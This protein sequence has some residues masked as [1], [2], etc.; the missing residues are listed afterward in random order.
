MRRLVTV[1]ALLAAA[2]AIAP[3]VGA[4]TY[5]T[6]DGNG[7]P[8]VG[9]LVS[10]TQYSDGTW[11]YCSGT[12]TS[13]IVFLTAA[14][15]GDEGEHLTVTFDTAY[16]AG[17]KTYT[18]TFHADPLYNQAQS[19]T[20][21]IAV[22]AV[23]KTIRAIAPASLPA[24]GSMSDLPSTQKFTSVGYGAYLVTKPARRPPVPL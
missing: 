16:V 22:V 9:G 4:I 2:L 19:D 1:V 14:H 12:L 18:G 17:D 23:D 20:H 3:T 11:I 6:V 24:A 5:G 7:H 8:N 15:C 10:P 21:D 13:P